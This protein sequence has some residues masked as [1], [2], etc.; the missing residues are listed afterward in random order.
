MTSGELIIVVEQELKALATN[1]VAVDY[2]NAVEDAVRETS[3]VLPNTNNE[4]IYWLK[5]RTKRNMVFMLATGVASSFQVKQIKLDQKFRN[6]KELYVD[7]DKV[8][9]EAQGELGIGVSDTFRLF[10]SKVDAGFASDEL[11]GE[12]TTYSAE[13]LVI[14]TPDDTE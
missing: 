6:L 12:D 13:Q 9:K 8:W 1:F 7:M 4:Q 10:G 14:V 5:Q 11:T 3:Y 2:T